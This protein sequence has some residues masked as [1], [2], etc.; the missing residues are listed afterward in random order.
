MVAMCAVVYL[1]LCTAFIA[2]IS[3]SLLQQ[4]QQQK[5]GFCAHSF[6]DFVALF[7]LK[8]KKI[9]YI[10]VNKLLNGVRKTS[11]IWFCCCFEPTDLCL[12]LVSHRYV[13]TIT[14]T[15]MLTVVVADCCCC[16]FCRLLLF[17]I[18]E[19]FYRCRLNERFLRYTIASCVFV[20]I[21]LLLRRCVP[22]T[23]HVR[24]VIS[25]CTVYSGIR[26]WYTKIL[27]V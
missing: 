8:R 24:S 9:I 22:T 27:I 11:H 23:S 18:D 21:E 25:V 17:A 13:F 12:D 5:S 14:I 7:F 1:C 20:F 26:R 6:N 4:Q 16:C 2:F 10:L 15:S 19:Q 3:Y